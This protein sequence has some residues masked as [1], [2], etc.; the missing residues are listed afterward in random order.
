MSAEE[1][2]THKEN[3]T[4]VVY[5]EHHKGTPFRIIANEE[6]KEV[7]ITI[8]KWK[9]GGPYKSII[10]AENTINTR[11]W[12]L[13][14]NSVIIMTKSTIDAIEEEKAKLGYDPRKG[15][16]MEIEIDRYPDKEGLID[17]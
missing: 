4:Q 8:G 1:L 17:K 7:Y 11:D 9:A 5:N 2:L 14:M 13:I 3:S 15:D 12:E 10:E 6:Q 16:K